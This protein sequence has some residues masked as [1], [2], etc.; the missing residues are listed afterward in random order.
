MDM[1]S[2][3]LIP[4]INMKDSGRMTISKEG[5]NILGMVETRMM[6]II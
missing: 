6:E 5:A 4:E 2:E 3:F 1:E